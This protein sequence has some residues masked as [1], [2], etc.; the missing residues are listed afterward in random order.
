MGV[1]GLWELLAPV[2]R[3]VSVETL[4]GKKL[5]IDASI[6]M[7]QFMKAMRDEKGEMVR[8][9]HI[10]GFFRRICKLLYLRT[11][12]VFVF[13][14]GTPALKRRTVIAR[15]RQRENAQA[16]IRKTAE[17]LLLNHLRTMRAKELAANLE[18]QRQENDAKGKRPIIDESTNAHNTEEGNDAG[19]NYSQEQLDE[20]L[21]ASLAAEESEASAFDA[22]ASGGAVPDG[23]EDDEEDEEIILPEMQ[24]K[25][26]PAVLAALPP[27][28]QLD[29]LV[30]MR[31]RL[32]AENRQ[33]YQK[34]KKAPERF[35]ELQIQAYL[36]TV[37]FRREI[38]V[39]QKTAAGR[40][41][42]GMQT[43]RIAS[44]ANREFIFSSSFNGNKQTLT[45]IEQGKVGA[46]ENR[47]PAVNMSTEASTQVIQSK[48]SGNN[49][50]SADVGTGKA[51]PDDV[52]TYLDDRGQLR[53]SRV[54]ALGIR[55][56]RD[57]QR[58]LDLMKEYDQE[59]EVDLE[60]RSESNTVA[61]VDNGEDD[62]CDTTQL[63]EIT[64]NNNNADVNDN[65]VVKTKE[66]TILNG[67]SIEI[68]FD[69]MMEC[70][71]T[72]DD[73]D[74]LFACLVSGDP[75]ID[76]TADKSAPG[77]QSSHSDSDVEW[78]EGDVTENILEGHM[79]D[80]EEFQCKEGFLDNIEVPSCLNGSRQTVSEVSLQEVSVKQSLNRDSDL[81]W[82]GEGMNK[83]TSSILERGM[84][85]T[86]DVDHGAGFQDIQASLALPDKSNKTVTKGAREEEADLQEAIRRS[87]EDVK[88]CSSVTDVCD[89]FLSDRGQDMV[90]EHTD[91]GSGYEGKEGPVVNAPAAGLGQPF[92]LTNIL[93]P[94][95]SK[96]DSAPIV[97]LSPDKRNLDMKNL[98]QD[99]GGSGA[100][101][102]EI[103]TTSDSRPEVTL[104]SITG[105]KAK[106]LGSEDDSGKALA[107]QVDISRDHATEMAK[108]EMHGY[109]STD[110]DEPVGSYSLV[111]DI[112][113]HEIMKDRL[114]EEMLFLGKE[115]E[116]LGIEQRKLERNAESVSGE[117]FAE[118]QELLQMFGLPYIIAPMEAEA[119]CAFMEMS[120]LVDGVVTD[121]SDA[122][123]FGAQ[124]VYKNIFD[125][126]KYVET[127]LM[128][129]IENEL[130]LDREKLIRM[131]LLL[132]S[133]YTE[134]VSGI[135]IVN[136]IEVVNA[137][138]EK[139]GLRD[140][141]EWIESPDPAILGTLDAEPGR[142]SR[143]KGSK[144][145]ENN[146]NNSSSEIE[147]SSLN[148]NVPE[149]AD[150]LRLKQNFM[151]NHRNVSKNWH[152]PSTFPS[153]A[154]I[155]AYASPQV[156][157]STEPFAW[158]K[159][160]LHVLRKLCW[161]KLGWGAAK[162]DE[163][164]LPVLKEY[165]KHE[166]QLRMEAF[167]S[168]NE[169]FAKIRSKRIEKAVKGMTGVKSSELME[170]TGQPKS[171][172][173]KKRKVKHSEEEEAV[174]PGVGPSALG[175]SG[176]SEQKNAVK[177]PTAKKSRGGRALPRNLDGHLD[178]AVNESGVEGR[179]LG[180]HGRGKRSGTW[181]KKR[182][183]PASGS[184]SSYNEGS[185]SER[186][187]E[188]QLD[189]TEEANEVRRSG[190]LRNSVN[191]TVV[192]DESDSN[193]SKETETCR[194]EGPTTADEP[195]VEQAMAET[196]ESDI[197]EK[198]D[199]NKLY[200]DNH[201]IE[202]QIEDPL[203]QKQ[204]SKDYLQFGG[205]FCTEDDDEQMETEIAVVE[206]SDHV[207][208]SAAGD[209]E[210]KQTREID[211]S[212][213]ASSPSRGKNNLSDSNLNPSMLGDGDAD[214]DDPE[215]DSGNCNQNLLRAM[216]NLR[217]KRKT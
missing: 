8:N 181:R 78:E 32:M 6:W 179:R 159:P 194:K 124:S 168:F 177:K 164:L 72:N 111:D 20:M 54:R 208:E 140:F 158:G 79:N 195:Y 129:D 51:F 162:A 212:A 81:E 104:L 31:E 82:E 33:K 143:R 109:V 165:N 38:D 17:K 110:K 145:S 128:K 205:G 55:M 58:N 63:R 147:G 60:K 200:P 193:D 28:L 170:G 120:N 107:K 70:E 217:R 3:R 125:D 196:T 203:D 173:G 155:S 24:G 153:D 13:D 98:N 40:G 39:V 174:R 157:K 209:H 34:V 192:S 85:D 135:G 183:S 47:P 64:D 156:D 171:R 172:G 22:S 11:K 71:Q 176:T 106:D 43:S 77:K 117:M 142:N 50:G 180:G 88:G 139:D 29:L 83:G 130:G 44:E 102:E 56:T 133:D 41:I 188:L 66:P 19:V 101:A 37:A 4:A 154:V 59:K 146:I 9:A 199:G 148:Q 182:N 119:Q 1:H 69:D 86:A 62:S 49:A 121:D 89:N 161:E 144:S 84:N 204:S 211:P 131:A 14:G 132:G 97:G 187:E 12:P 184:E 136:A 57:L 87:L 90:S 116:D 76:F 112:Q 21:A 68:S 198:D 95:F 163:L 42:G 216:P 26:D 191:Y 93:K 45:A 186:D 36:K 214:G 65:R 151:D 123:L 53:V 15:R 206:E 16:K 126:R 213:A 175:T 2:G 99:A 18:K 134:G 52:E 160:D 113:E 67:N 210:A 75:V 80:E 27:S 23:Q 141:R 96:A 137:F 150:N 169:R 138:P 108:E 207:P 100:L 167:Y 202:C 115:R 7:I 103:L 30:Q 5:A 178:K 74:E 61:T 48:N 105:K 197:I 215:R 149:R 73:D 25:I 46:D 201:E 91:W 166:T 10:L 94:N 190:R 122:F 152:I 185:N 118:C 35:S 92:G 127:Y 189:R 114:E